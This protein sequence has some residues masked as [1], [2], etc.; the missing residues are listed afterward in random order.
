MTSESLTTD[1]ITPT[2]M[3]GRGYRGLGGFRGAICATSSNEL[4]QD[5]YEARRKEAAVVITE[6]TGDMAAWALAANRE[7]LQIERAF[8]AQR[9]RRIRLNPKSTQRNLCRRIVCNEVR[10]SQFSIGNFRDL[11]VVQKLVIASVKRVGIVVGNLL[12]GRWRR[13]VAIFVMPM[14]M[15][16]IV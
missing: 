7:K 11:T 2:E 1:A 5:T 16:A 8:R 12:T 13:V 15:V 4:Q 6:K 10:R 3:A 14:I 9:R